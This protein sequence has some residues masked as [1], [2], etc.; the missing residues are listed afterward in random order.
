MQSDR[1]TV[2]FFHL[3]LV[4]VLC[5]GPDKDAYSIKGGC[6]LRFFFDSVRYSEDI[7]LDV[8]E[9]VPVHT[10]KDKMSRL[11]ASP[12]LALPLKSR[13]IELGQVSAPKQT[14]TTQRWKV[15]LLAGSTRLHTKVEFSR[16]PSGE[17]AVAEAVGRGVLEEHRVMPL[18]AGHYPLPAALRQKVEALAMRSQVQARDVFDLAVLFAKAGDT[19]EALRSVR[20]TLPAAVERAMDLSYGDYKSQVVSWLRSDQVDLYG[21]QEAWNAL[22]LQVVDTLERAR[23]RDV[24]RER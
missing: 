13:G 11:L 7:D 14:D 3:Q 24:E 22:Q 20:E 1:Q 8:S 5:S 23:T 12:A 10:L 17:V 21:A 4:R 9:R 16:R 19:R 6:N 2:E 18:I 15:E